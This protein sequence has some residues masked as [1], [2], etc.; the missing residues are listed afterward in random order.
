MA[1]A[2][3]AD[4]RVYDAARVLRV[5]G[6]LNHKHEPP[7]EV[8]LMSS[9]DE[10]YT[11]D[12]LE[13]V[14]P[15]LPAPWGERTT[16]R[17][18]AAETETSPTQTVLERLGGAS[19][20][21]SGWKAHCPAHDDENPSLSISEAADGSCLVHCFAD[22][23]TKAIMAALGLT[24]ADLFPH[25]DDGGDEGDGDSLSLVEMLIDVAEHAAVELFHDS[26]DKR[27]RECRWAT[28]PRCGR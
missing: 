4:A 24:M 12:E 17:A 27:T 1:A 22:C 20:T 6:T 16:S 21:G 11:V 25:G 2:L 3:G 14:T 7:T 5:P 23:E 10:R 8:K 19:E 18:K 13:S 9:N 28:T 15:Q 26:A